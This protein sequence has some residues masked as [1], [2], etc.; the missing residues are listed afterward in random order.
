[1]QTKFSSIAFRL[2]TGGV[3]ILLVPL[4]IVGTMSQKTSR[5]ALIS[6]A[7][8]R[9][10][11]TSVALSRLTHSILQ[12]ELNMAKSLAAGERQIK[13][14]AAVKENGVENSP[15]EIAAL[16]GNLKK[17]LS[18]MDRHYKG[19]FVTDDKGLVYTGTDEN[20]NEMKGMNYSESVFFKQASKTDEPVLSEII[21]SDKDTDFQFI[22]CAAVKSET[23][24][25]LGTVGTIINTDFLADLI[26]G[27]KIGETGYGYMANKNGLVNIHPKKELIL[28]LDLPH[29]QGMENI[30]ARIV[31]GETGVDTY[32]FNGIE[33]V[34]G[35][36][37]VGYN[38]WMIVTA[39]EKNEVT[40]SADAARNAMITIALFAVSITVVLIWFF[41]GRIVKPINST[42]DSLKDIAQGRGDLTLRLDVKSRDEIGE[43]ARWFNLF[44]DKLQDIIRQIAQGVDLL[45]ASSAGLSA[46]SETMTATTDKTSDISSD[47]SDAAQTLSD[48]MV[49]AASA[50]TQ[51]CRNTDVV[52]KAA[53]EMS[54][55]IQ[56]ISKNSE[57][58]RVIAHKASEDVAASSE[59]IALLGDAAQAIG[60]V[61][62]TITDISEQVNL[63]ALNATIEAARAGEAGKG[64]AVVANEIKELANQTAMATRDIESRID[65]IQNV[66]S[67]TI[68]RIDTIN[69]VISDV[70]HVV[71]GI[72]AAVEEQTASTSEIAE[73]VSQAAKGILEINT[74]VNQSAGLS[75][76][77]SSRI[78]DVKNSAREIAEGSRQINQSYKNLATLA[79]NL[80][81][82]VG[83]FKF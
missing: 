76:D 29:T 33:K 38:G 25:F 21:K 57:K 58:A 48:N 60:R 17:K 19:I 27:L 44:M 35:F 40:A 47:V 65:D 23:G 70:S 28:A 68:E 15:E 43:L 52:A 59:R 77:I 11:D 2:V 54:A 61:V 42:V 51:S 18:R 41:S 20:G 22:T 71:T 26:S 82:L 63:L 6:M 7:M 37:P 49:S 5:S 66:T 12:A 73:N 80:R 72:A 1:M 78:A 56:D 55:T 4:V 69:S 16:F 9:T 31:N 32:T 10:H 34:A 50:M 13:V 74:N 39:Q 3:L 67:E 53:E 45:T 30:A 83:Q 36:S 79:D 8:G 64:F 75:T 46:V 14:S 81:S 24:D 62:D